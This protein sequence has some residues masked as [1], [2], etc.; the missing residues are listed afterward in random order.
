MEECGAIGTR[1]RESREEKG[2]TQGSLG[3]AIGVD[4]GSIIKWEGGKAVPNTR[5]LDKLSEKLG[6]PLA[7]LWLGARDIEIYQKTGLDDDSVAVLRAVSL[8]EKNKDALNKFIGN[9]LFADLITYTAKCIDYKAYMGDNKEKLDESILQA[10]P[11]EY[12]KYLIEPRSRLR[13]YTDQIE[14][15]IKAIVYEMIREAK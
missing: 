4:R 6:I 10:V 5:H 1:I 14:D 13:F 3:K 11:K 9:S 2:L 8:V 12:H 7:W 15:T